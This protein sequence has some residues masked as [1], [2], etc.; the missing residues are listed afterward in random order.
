MS[1]E[2]IPS[3]RRSARTRVRAKP[4]ASALEHLDEMYDK[5]WKDSRHGAILWCDE[6]A[7][8]SLGDVHE[9]PLGRVPK[10]NLDRT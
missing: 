4:H 5:L 3:R 9:S 10:L 7:A 1:L 6:A 2:G 8:D